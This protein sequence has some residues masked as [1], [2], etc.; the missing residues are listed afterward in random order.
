MDRP[1]IPA[2]LLA[3]VSPS[4]RSARAPRRRPLNASAS[5][6]CSRCS[7]RSGQAGACLNQ[8]ARRL[9]AGALVAGVDLRAALA[10]TL[11][12]L[13]AVLREQLA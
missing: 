11:A 9:H 13:N 8:I 5:S 2:W 7:D 10:D 4:R 1:T 12:A 6:N 3:A